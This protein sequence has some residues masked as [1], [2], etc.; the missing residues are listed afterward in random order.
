[1]RRRRRPVSA[2]SAI[3]EARPSATS[4]SSSRPSFGR[5][6]ACS[7][8]EIETFSGSP[9]YIWRATEAARAEGTAGSGTR[10][11]QTLAASPTQ[12]SR[13]ARGTRKVVE[14]RDQQVRR[15]WYPFCRKGGI[16]P[17]W[18][19]SEFDRGRS[20]ATPRSGEDRDRWGTD[21]PAGGTFRWVAPRRCST[22]RASRTDP[23]S[24]G[25]A[26]VGRAPALRSFCGTVWDV[27]PR[28]TSSRSWSPRTNRR[29]PPALCPL[30]RHRAREAAPRLRPGQSR[31][32]SR[33]PS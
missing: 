25:P 14:R 20:M 27:P 10:R 11:K 6:R 29:P 15:P 19:P 26:G 24:D 1:M 22:S 30:P 7:F 23:E 13:G 28:A 17:L 9:V 33:R 3:D 18:P 5:E 2:G 12:P 4:T 21:R 31:T 32:P 16:V 8:R